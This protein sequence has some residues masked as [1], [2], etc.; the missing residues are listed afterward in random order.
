MGILGN[1]FGGKKLKQPVNLGVLVNDIHSHFIPGIDDGAENIEQAMELLRHMSRFGYKKVITTPH[2]MG[3]TYRNGPHNILPGLEKIREAAKAEGINITIEAAAEYYL[4][5]DL[6]DK[7]EKKDI[8]AFSGNK[9]LFEMPFI[10]EPQNL[11]NVVFKLQLAAYQPVLA[12]AERYGFWHSEFQKITDI[13]DKGVLIQVN[14][15]SFSG[16]YGPVVKKIAEKLVDEK[17][18]DLLGSDCH[19]LGHVS[20]IEQACS[21]PYLQKAIETCPLQNASL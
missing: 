10:S 1:L 17:M 16:H 9:V 2:I 13:R 8:L 12:H 14:I 5:A 15:S 6:E 19:H 3:D 7:I 4:D 20:L 11:A 21:F 18:I